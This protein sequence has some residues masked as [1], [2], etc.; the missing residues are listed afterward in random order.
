MYCIKGHN[1][2][3][4]NVCVYTIVSLLCV[5]SYDVGT[6]MMVYSTACNFWVFPIYKATM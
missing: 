3:T 4:F 5:S 1:W 6:Y 2:P